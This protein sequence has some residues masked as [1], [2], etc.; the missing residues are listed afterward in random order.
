MRFRE[1]KHSLRTYGH[2]PDRF[3][4]S[5]LRSLDDEMVENDLDVLRCKSRT[6]NCVLIST[7]SPSACS[8]LNRLGMEEARSRYEVV[9]F[10]I[11]DDD[12]CWTCWAAAAA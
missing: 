4:R 5:L 7:A 8:S 3:L 12:W 6:I 9:A 10:V 2:D 1:Q 11:V